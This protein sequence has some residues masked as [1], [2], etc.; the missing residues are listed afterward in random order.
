MNIDEETKRKIIV[1]RKQHK[2]K[3]REIVEVVGKSSR[4]VTAQY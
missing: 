3:I 4:D 2:K 1:L